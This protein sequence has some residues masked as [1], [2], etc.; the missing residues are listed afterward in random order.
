MEEAELTLLPEEEQVSDDFL[1]YFHEN[2]YYAIRTRSEEANFSFCLSAK[3]KEEAISEAVD[4]IA[5]F[6]IRRAVKAPILVPL[7]F[8]TLYKE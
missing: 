2:E 1:L 4:A 8:E 3:T 6:I 5:F 7:Q